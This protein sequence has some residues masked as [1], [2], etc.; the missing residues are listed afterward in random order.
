MSSIYEELLNGREIAKKSLASS[1]VSF[2]DENFWLADDGDDAVDVR[3]EGQPQRAARPDDRAW[4]R[5][6]RQKQCKYP[7]M[8]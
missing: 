1:R 4:S 7:M 8:N 5:R 2:L 6:E 3:S